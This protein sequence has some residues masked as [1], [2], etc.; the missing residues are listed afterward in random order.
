MQSYEPSE[1]PW[2]FLSELESLEM[3]VVGAGMF[4]APA[5]STLT[6][7]S[8]SCSSTRHDTEVS[9]SCPRL[10]NLWIDIHRSELDDDA[11]L[12]CIQRRV[13]LVGP[14]LHELFLRTS[15]MGDTNA[16]PHV[17]PLCIHEETRKARPSECADV[18]ALHIEKLLQFV[19]TVEFGSSFPSRGMDLPEFTRERI[20]RNGTIWG[21]SWRPW[22][23]WE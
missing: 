7:S 23:W 16:S 18:Q 21:T 19:N 4:T 14:A 12:K 22:W 3:F 15:K 1:L 10:R 8:Q 6:P 20:S 9:V 13:E 11:L 2:D 17:V 5:I